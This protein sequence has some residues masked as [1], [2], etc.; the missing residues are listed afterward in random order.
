[1]N[2]RR[3]LYRCQNI[4]SIFLLFSNKIEDKR[5]SLFKVDK[6]VYTLDYGDATSSLVVILFR[7]FIKVKSLVNSQNN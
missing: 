5:D 3:K 1:M 2:Y 7:S 4:F 6:G